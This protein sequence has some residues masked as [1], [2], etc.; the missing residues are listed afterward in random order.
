MNCVHTNC[1]LDELPTARV[2]AICCG[3]PSRDE[4]TQLDVCSTMHTGAS[5]GTPEV[6]QTYGHNAHADSNVATGA[7]GAGLAMRP[8][9]LPW[10]NSSGKWA[11]NTVVKDGCVTLAR[12]DVEAAYSSFVCGAPGVDKA[13]NNNTNY[14]VRASLLSKMRWACTRR[15]KCT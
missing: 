9:C 5:I 6:C 8:L 4:T 10:S 2:L 11:K 13:P 12:V 1:M 14:V 3:Q 15:G 7:R